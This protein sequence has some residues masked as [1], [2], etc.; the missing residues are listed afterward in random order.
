[1]MNAN[2]SLTTREI[3]DDQGVTPGRVRQILRLSSLAP[4]ILGELDSM[5]PEELRSFGENKL[6]FLVPLDPADQI[7]EFQWLKSQHRL[8]L[9]H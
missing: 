9:S 8:C 2:P 5:L 1:M 4:E 7:V 3:A 6:R